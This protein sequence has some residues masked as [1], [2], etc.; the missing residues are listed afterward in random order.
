MKHCYVEK[1]PLSNRRFPSRSSN[2][3]TSALYHAGY[4]MYATRELQAQANGRDAGGNTQ[5]HHGK[6]M[7]GMQRNQVIALTYLHDLTWKM[8]RLRKPF[9]DVQVVTQCPVAVQIHV[10]GYC[11][12]T[13]WVPAT[14]SAVTRDQ[15]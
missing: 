3:V 8:L 2:V 9:A 7:L 12:V 4:L 11:R 10:R 15:P 13:W 6:T 5:R 1:K 14:C